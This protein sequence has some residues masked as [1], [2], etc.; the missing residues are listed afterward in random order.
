MKSLRKNLI[1]KNHY[2]K[3]DI[4]LKSSKPE[5]RTDLTNL[6]FITIDGE[7]AKDFDDAVYCKN[8]KIITNY[9]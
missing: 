9:M 5:G 2:R 4:E 3:K 6:D 8:K 1:K 7:D